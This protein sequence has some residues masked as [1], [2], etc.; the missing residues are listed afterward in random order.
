MGVGRKTRKQT[1][2]RGGAIIGKGAYGKVIKPVPCLAMT[3]GPDEVGKLM[4]KD[5]AVLERVKLQTI[6]SRLPP[7][8]A[9]YA[10]YINPTGECAVDPA[11]P[12]IQT[13]FP[14]PAGIASPGIGLPVPIPPDKDI[15][16]YT[17]LRYSDAGGN[18]GNI[19]EV[20][21]GAADMKA[22]GALQKSVEDYN[23]EI[24][25]FLHKLHKLFYAVHIL[26]SYKIVHRDIKPDN[27]TIAPN[28]HIT[29]IDFG[30]ATILDDPQE[31]IL[32]TSG[33]NYPYW[34][35]EAPAIIDERGFLNFSTRNMQE[36]YNAVMYGRPYRGMV[37]GPPLS[38]LRGQY[39]FAF[40][41][42][43][44]SN[45]DIRVA[46]IFAVAKEIRQACRFLIEKNPEGY[47]LLGEFLSP[48]PEYFSIDKVEALIDLWKVPA[49]KTAENKAKI[50]QIDTL[51]DH[52]RSFLYNYFD[53]FNLGI[54][55]LSFISDIET[56]LKFPLSPENIAFIGE[57]KGLGKQMIVTEISARLLPNVAFHKFTE[58][59]SRYR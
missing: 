16:N 6:L 15:T 37:G 52:I 32:I 48:A 8:L 50:D 4:M 34:P 27:L 42:L 59:E 38:Y 46:H 26:H 21:S 19:S 33:Y 31:G 10:F 40:Q 22:Y 24:K 49:N 39:Q 20:L 36:T 53:V 18:L 47:N 14:P 29:L 11:N 41:G 35:M 28:G 5:K 43:D 12:D 3:Y 45:K 13:L 17:V 23:K 54:C 7:D 55:M 2:K 30:L 56:L 25:S 1:I 44:G 57:L 9:Y 51:G 58:V